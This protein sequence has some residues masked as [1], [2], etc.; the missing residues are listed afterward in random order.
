[1]SLPSFSIRN[2]GPIAQ[3]T[4][5]LHPLTILIGKNNTGKTYA[6]QAVYAVYKALEMP[7]RFD[8]RFPRP[9][10]RQLIT[11]GE[12]DELLNRLHASGS[13]AGVL[14]GSLL[15]KAESWMN[16]RLDHVGSLLEDRLTVYFDLD[17]VS[18]LKRWRSDGAMHVSVISESSEF[19]PAFLLEFSHDDDSTPAH[20]SRR[21][22]G[23]DIPAS[24]LQGSRISDMLTDLAAESWDADNPSDVSSSN[25]KLRRY[26]SSLMAEVIWHEHLLPSVGL[27]GT[28]HYLPAGRSGLLE[29]WTDVVRLR[30]EQD[31]DRLALSGREPA[32][33]G[34]IALDFLGQLQELMRPRS[35]RRRV[36]QAR[37]LKIPRPAHSRTGYSPR[38]SF[39]RVKAASTHVEELIDGEIVFHRERDRIPSFAYTKDGESI[40]VQRSSSMVAELAPLMSWIKHMLIPGDILLIDEPE[41]HMHPEAVIAVAQTLV[42]LA[43]SGVRVLC[44]THSS[45]FLHQVSNCMLR[46]TM[47]HDA[48]PSRGA[49]I[50]VDDIGVYCFESGGASSGTRIVSRSHRSRM[51]HTRRR[52][53]RSSGT[54]RGGNRRPDRRTHMS[55]T[56]Q[57]SAMRQKHASLPLRDSRTHIGT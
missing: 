2:L 47:Q 7:D 51:G 17:D 9:E 5:R 13:D 39:G 49:T 12:A 30:L 27:N 36:L 40:P 26:V 55:V 22:L 41:A 8:R 53:C 18:D 57:L 29:A 42:E 45:D 19:E 50:G 44:T 21:V 25:G 52:A 37:R 38:E 54:S 32:A 15:E 3:G 11:A 34:G 1:M 24:C 31:R 56:D 20:S 14:S 48:I 23:V 4:V 16:A 33:L 6:A 46:S 43:G 28:V 10:E 35:Y